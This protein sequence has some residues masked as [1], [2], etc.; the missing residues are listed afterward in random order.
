MTETEILRQIVQKQDELDDIRVNQ[1]MTMSDFNSPTQYSLNKKTLDHKYT[2]LCNEIISIRNKLASLRQQLAECK[3]D[4]VPQQLSAYPGGWICP[5]CQKVH[6]FMV[7]E[8]NC[9]PNT[10][11]RTSYDNNYIKGFKDC[12][13]WMRNEILK[14]NKIE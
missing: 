10:I 2:A 4:E 11:T 3:E 12:A 13:E 1:L 8:C 7:T 14:R 6:S 9:P 5:R